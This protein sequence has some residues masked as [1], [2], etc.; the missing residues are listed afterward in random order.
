MGIPEKSK[1]L[2][3]ATYKKIQYWQAKNRVQATNEK[4]LLATKKSKILIRK[5]IFKYLKE[6]YHSIHSATKTK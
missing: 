1:T 6:A 3:E 2:Y 5:R 4:C